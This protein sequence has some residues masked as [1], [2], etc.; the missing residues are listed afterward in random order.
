[1]PWS[2][3]RWF[4]AAPGDFSSDCVAF[5]PDEGPVGSAAL[6]F[7]G[8]AELPRSDDGALCWT[9]EPA[10]G[11]SRPIPVPCAFAKPAPAINAT[12]ATDIKKRLVME[13]LL[14]CLHCP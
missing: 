4:L 12:A 8:A 9:V 13:Y 14:T 10:D 3:V 2:S 5:M 7:D 6:R 11:A 1:M